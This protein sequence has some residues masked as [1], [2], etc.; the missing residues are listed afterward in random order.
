M[1]NTKVTLDGPSLETYI[2][3]RL[4]LL[5]ESIK[6]S[7]RAQSGALGAAIEAVKASIV[8]VDLRY[9]QRFQASQKALEAALIAQREAIA[10]AMAS[11]DRAV[12]KAEL[13]TEKRFES[14]NEFRGTL[15]QQ[16]RTLIPRSEVDVL[17]RGL[18][19]KIN[20]VTKIVDQ[21][22]AERQ[23]VKGGWGYAVGA[24]GLLLTLAS[25]LMM[26]WKLKG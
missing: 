14:V 21:L 13:A 8:A 19:E 1:Q 6:S 2:E 20:Q 25:L 18:E 17:V 10:A 5:Q 16:Q 4:N 12:T 11:A 15:D 3:T 24:A 26:F 23:G 9:E 22:I 7:E